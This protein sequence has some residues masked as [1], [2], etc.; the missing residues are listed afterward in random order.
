MRK[1]LAMLMMLSTMAQADDIVY[2]WQ[3][4]TTYTDGSA[5]TATGER[6]YIL[7]VSKTNDF[8]VLE[9][10][11]GATGTTV[12]ADKLSAG[13]YYARIATVVAGRTS[14]WSPTIS[15]KID[16]PPAAPGSLRGVVIT[17]NVTIGA[18]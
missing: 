3:H 16:A 11:L 17:V 7:H 14:A 8:T 18:P 4:A 6:S 9:K 1:L 2:T 13:T 5:I 12:T 10:N 15:T